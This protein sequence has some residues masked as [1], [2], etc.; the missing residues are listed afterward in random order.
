MMTRFPKPNINNKG[1]LVRG[2]GALI[3]FASAGFAFTVSIW[4]GL[5]LVASGAFVFF[6][7]LRGWCVLRARGIKTKL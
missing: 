6:E 2:V 4:L 7:A 1:R 3:L 5:A